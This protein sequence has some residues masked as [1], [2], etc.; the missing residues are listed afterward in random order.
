MWL[1]DHGGLFQVASV[2][3]YW[4]WGSGSHKTKDFF[5]LNH[6]CNWQHT[7]YVTDLQT[8]M[9]GT[10]L[11]LLA[12]PLSYC[13]LPSFIPF[14]AFQ[15]HFLPPSCSPCRVTAKV[16]HWLREGS[17]GTGVVN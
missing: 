14:S 11:P 13:S 4:G 16:I 12:K 8:L 15:V 5:S 17:V 9:G 7:D 6:P 2:C 3:L 10:F 1:E